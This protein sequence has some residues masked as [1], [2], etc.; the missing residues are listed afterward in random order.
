MSQ[1]P[2]QFKGTLL[3]QG[4]LQQPFKGSILSQNI[5]S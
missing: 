4:Y 5:L 2:T 3:S 1:N